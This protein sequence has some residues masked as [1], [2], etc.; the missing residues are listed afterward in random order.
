MTSDYEHFLAAKV[1][2][3][4]RTGFE[5]DLDDVHPALFDHQRRIV[6]WAVRGGRR[7]IFAA[8]GMRVEQ[9]EWWMTG[10]DNWTP[11]GDA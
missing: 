10:G 6:Q 1:D 4:S 9:L 11:S 2:F 5:I 3:D 8:F 7:A